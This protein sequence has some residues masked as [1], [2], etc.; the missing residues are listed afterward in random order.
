[1]TSNLR[2]VSLTFILLALTS[3]KKDTFQ[4]RNAEHDFAYFGLIKGRFVEYKVQSIIHDSLLNQHDTTTYYYK[5]V[6]GDEYYDNEG[7]LGYEFLRY[8]KD[9]LQKPYQ[10]ISKW[11]AMIAE[12]KAQL[13]EE[14]QRKIKLV[15]PII[16]SQKWESNVYNYLDDQ[17]AQYEQIDVPY[18][19]GNF[20]TDSSISVV[21]Y[22]YKT[23]ID[24]RLEGER[25]A[26]GVGMIEKTSKELYYQFGSTTPYKGKESYFRIINFGME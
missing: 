6:I 11:I 15:F 14:N 20:S 25:Y 3:C 12:N 7:H 9:S 1:M 24:D 21:Y 16:F 13:V 10:F 19:N 18:S 4:P 5:T 2:F 23:L 8:Q 26:K 17:E 22:R